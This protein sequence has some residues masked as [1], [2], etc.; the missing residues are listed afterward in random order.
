[1]KTRSL[2]RLDDQAA[3]LK[4]LA[5]GNREIEKGEFRDAEEVFAELDRENSELMAALPC[6]KTIE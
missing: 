5:M 1:M 6:K 4:I 2:K 3:L